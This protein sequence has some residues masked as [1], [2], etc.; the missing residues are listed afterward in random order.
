MN[1]YNKKLSSYYDLLY[2]KKDYNKE[3]ELIKKYSQG[4]SLLDIGAGT[5]SHSILLSNH[6]DK[7][8]ATDF[9]ESMIDVG[10]SK[11]DRL[12]IK[13][14]KS[15]SGNLDDILF[16]KEYSTVISM[17]NVV[18]HILTL[19]DLFIFFSNV[20]K[21]LETDGVFIFDCWNSVNC[22]I[23]TPKEYSKKEFHELGNTIIYETKTTTD[24]IN[25][26][27]NMESTINVYDDSSLLETI[28]FGLTHR[29]WTIDFL[30]EMLKEMGFELIKMIPYFDDTMDVSENDS[31]ITF[32]FKKVEKW[33][34]YILT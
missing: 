32:I 12:G 9:S 4:N 16:L 13:N 22:L 18:N 17:F 6:F 27:C 10:M 14:I 34:K 29:L 21:F 3:C 2:S 25:L 23:D 5:L 19:S 20:D 26:I 30:K 15:H 28:E 11:V 7:I 33:N 31:R 8:L 1:S 24:K